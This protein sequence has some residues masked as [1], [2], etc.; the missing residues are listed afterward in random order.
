MSTPVPFES[1][2][3][4]EGIVGAVRWRETVAGVIPPFITEVKSRG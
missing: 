1:L 2:L 4:I 3:D